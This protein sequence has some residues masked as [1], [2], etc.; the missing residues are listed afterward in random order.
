MLQRRNDLHIVQS[1]I[2]LQA[3]LDLLEQGIAPN[4]ATS[5]LSP[6]GTGSLRTLSGGGERIRTLGSA[7]RL[8]RRQCG[9]G[10]TPPDPGGEWPLLGPPPDNS[11]GV[12]RPATARMTGPPVDRPNSDEHTKPLP[13]KRGT[14]RSNPF[15]SSGESTNHRF[16]PDLTGSPTVS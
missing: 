3:H 1:G 11:I 7:M 10:V 15:P 13:T 12:R 4:N 16:L 8:H 5:A 14:E 2:M 6:R 9:G